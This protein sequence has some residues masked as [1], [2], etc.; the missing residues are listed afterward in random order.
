MR[1]HCASNFDHPAFGAIRGPVPQEF[2]RPAAIH[3]VRPA[4]GSL[5]RS[6]R[7]CGFSEDRIADLLAEGIV[8]QE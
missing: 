4:S 2:G 3:G 1:E 8:R 7:E 6:L 5:H